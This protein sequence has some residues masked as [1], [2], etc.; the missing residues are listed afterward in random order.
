MSFYQKTLMPLLMHLLIC[1]DIILTEHFP[2][3][4]HI[5]GTASKISGVQ[6][7]YQSLETE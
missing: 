4:H 2:M 7:A 5:G 3:K 6:K 1:S